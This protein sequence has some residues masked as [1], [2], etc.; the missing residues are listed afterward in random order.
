MSYRLV[1]AV[2][3]DYFGRISPGSRGPW[4]LVCNVNR[5]ASLARISQLDEAA[6]FIN[7][8]NSLTQPRVEAW[9]R[10]D[11][12]NQ[13]AVLGTVEDVDALIDTLL[14]SPV[15]ENL[16]ALYSAQRPLLPSGYPHH[17]LMVGVDGSRRVGVLAFM[18]SDGTWSPWARRKTTGMT[19]L[20]TV[21]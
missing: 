16:A 15:D 17:E 1:C 14:A 18:E 8:R 19:K 7:G 2:L 20:P 13:P 6:R 5:S 9:Y 4:R 3:S 21:R 10:R 11:H 12:V